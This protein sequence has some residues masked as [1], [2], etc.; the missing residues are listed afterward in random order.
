VVERALTGSTS[1]E[2]WA[3]ANVRAF[4]PVVRAFTPKLV[5]GVRAFT[6]IQAFSFVLSLP[7]I[8][9]NFASCKSI[10]TRKE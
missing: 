6:P 4:T 2:K 7:K 5:P 10:W 8:V 9:P 3:F 1:G